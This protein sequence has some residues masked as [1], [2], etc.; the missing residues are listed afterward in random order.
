MTESK[1]TRRNVLGQRLLATFF[2]ILLLTLVGSA[3][4]LW[5]L[6]RVNDATD[7]M[8]QQSVATERLVADAY[9]YQEINAASYKAM[10]LSSEPE[11]GDI[12]AADILVTQQRYD[13][14]MKQLAG[15]LQT[16]QEQALLQKISAASKDFVVAQAELVAARDS[17]LT[18]RI[19]KVHA[20]RFMPSS[21]A[22]LAAVAALAESQ[23]QAIDIAASQIARWSVMART[24]LIV[25]SAAALV[26]GTVLSLWLVRSITRPIRQASDTADRVASLDL[27][28][29]IEGHE[30]DEA[31]RL[32]TSLGVMQG[33]LRALVQQVRGS[34]QNISSASTDIASGNADL[35]S[36]TEEAASSLQQTAA[37]LEL[38][39]QAVQQSAQAA[40]RAEAMASSA[41]VLAVQGGKAVTEMVITMQEILQSSRLIED[42]VSVIDGIAFQTNLLALNAAVEAAHAGEQGRGF[43]VV[44]AEVRSLASRSGAA[45]REIKT[46]INA[47]VQRVETGAQLVNQ[48]GQTMNLTVDAIQNVAHSI[49]EV[50]GATQAQTRDIAQIN[51]AVSQLDQ[52]T[53]QNSALVDQSAAA[54]ESL[55]R[56]AHE[57]AALISRFVLPA[58]PG[59]GTVVAL[60]RHAPQLTWGASSQPA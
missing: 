51:A 7:R 28:Q 32:L 49:S 50:T 10:A 37:S 26:L 13:G 25:F 42:I 6:H 46:L 43:S 33:A 44:A 23:R 14:L 56:Q 52:M 57:L 4:G 27:R 2:T 31:G 30:R 35:S 60:Q 48:A 29:D 3:I 1:T 24:A 16:V 58:Q 17:G 38:V 39:T 41:A 15:R 54:S 18:E 12:L 19:R 22:L 5:S 36:R 47:S 45:A 53:Q 11:V 55:R 40:H 34:T 21:N 8:V 9:R 20:E 59:G